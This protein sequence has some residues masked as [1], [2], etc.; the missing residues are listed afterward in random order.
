[1]SKEALDG[2]DLLI[3]CLLKEGITKIF[4]IVVGE[5]VRIYYDK[6]RWVRV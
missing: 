3:K 4:G 1:M 5:L 2:G 6:V